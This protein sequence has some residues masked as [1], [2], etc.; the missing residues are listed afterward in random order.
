MVATPTMSADTRRSERSH[1]PHHRRTRARRT[2]RRRV[3]HPPRARDHRA[4]GRR[5]SDRYAPDVVPVN[6]V[7]RDGDSV[8]RSHDGVAPRPDRSAPGEPA[9][10][11]VRLVPSHRMERPGARRRRARRP[12]GRSSRRRPRRRRLPRHLGAR[13]PAPTGSHAR[14]P[15][16]AVVASSCISSRSTDGATC[17][18]RGPPV[19]GHRAHRGRRQRR[20][21]PRRAS[22]RR[23]ASGSSAQERIGRLG[24]SVGSLPVILPVNYVLDGARSCSAPRTATRPAPRSS[25]SV[26]CLEIDQFDRFEHSGWSVLATGTTR[27][28]A[29]ARSGR[30]VRAAPRRPVG[31]DGARAGSS[32]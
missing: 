5:P 21:R 10:R 1:G 4:A 20:P 8:F 12:R 30:D 3:R 2:R 14:R 24:L 17:D 23:R 13:R 7:V 25:G 11:P 27:R 19:R 6:F 26:A 28:I 15:D 16:D 18:G 9:G 32:S 22:T 29:A 31:A